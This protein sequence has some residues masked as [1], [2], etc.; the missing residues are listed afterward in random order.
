MSASAV[1]RFSAG[2][3]VRDPKRWTSLT[4]SLALQ[5][6]QSLTSYHSVG[7]SPVGSNGPSVFQLLVSLTKDLDGKRFTTRADVRLSSP[8]HRLLEQIS[9]RPGYKN[10]VTERQMLTRH[11]RVSQGL[12]C[13]VSY[14]CATHTW[15]LERRSRHQSVRCLIFYIASTISFQS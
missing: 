8:G 11:S 4:T 6:G 5:A 1:N 13:T 10:S 2:C 14:L 12:M 7:T 15:N 3:F 9:S